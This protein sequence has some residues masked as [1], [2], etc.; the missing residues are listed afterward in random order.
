MKEAS[1][2]SHPT[3][4]FQASN[5]DEMGVIRE[6]NYNL[7]HWP[8][9]QDVAITNFLESLITKDPLPPSLRETL[10]ATEVADRLRDHLAPYA[11]EGQKEGFERLCKDVGELAVSF[12][13]L[14]SSPS[15]RT[16]FALIQNDMCRLFHTDAI[17]L[18]LLCTYV[19]PG[20]LWVPDQFVNWDKMNEPS[21]EARVKDMAE[22][23][24]FA[25]FE[26]GVLKGAMYDANNGQAVLHKSPTVTDH[27]IVRALLRIDSQ[28]AW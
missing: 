3:R 19:G 22:V 14:A 2:T 16:T 21:N 9:P 12:S 23:R 24:Q 11:S 15:L 4:D 13:K 20:T 6:P 10:K 17:E 8:R 5:W 27:K 18:R 25:P 1:L 26:L 28:V 7:V